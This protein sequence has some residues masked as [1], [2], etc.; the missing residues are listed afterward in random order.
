MGVKARA[1][2]L[3][4]WMTEHRIG[5]LKMAKEIGVCANTIWRLRTGLTSPTVQT[6]A[7]IEEYTNGA[8]TLRDFV[9][10]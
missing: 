6:L 5:D 4:D 7:K 9:R 2:K 8:V 3:A 1:M 10:N